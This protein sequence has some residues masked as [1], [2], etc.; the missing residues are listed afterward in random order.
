MLTSNQRRQIG[1]RLQRRMGN[2]IA[3]A[4]GQQML[5]IALD[6]IQMRFDLP[7]LL[8]Q[9]VEA[10]DDG[11]LLAGD[12]LSGPPLVADLVAVSACDLGSG[13]VYPGE[14]LLGLRYALHAAG[15]REVIS[16]LWPVVDQAGAQMMTRFHGELHAGSDTDRALQSAQ[17]ELIDDLAVR[18]RVVRGVGGL[19][20]QGSASARVHPFYWAGFVLDG[21]LD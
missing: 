9:R 5:G 19:I 18:D 6:G 2:R 14:G 4:Q 1:H 11:L 10:G 17:R 21:G 3:E 13:R 15:A 20:A 7:G 8:G 16:S 12:L